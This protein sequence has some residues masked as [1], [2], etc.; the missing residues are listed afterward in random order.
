MQG[1]DAPELL[2]QLLLG[3]RRQSAA[4]AGLLRSVEAGG[5]GSGAAADGDLPW[6]TG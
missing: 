2:H 4:L 3:A 1:L 5:L 6:S